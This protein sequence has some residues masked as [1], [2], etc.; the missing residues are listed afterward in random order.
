MTPSLPTVRLTRLDDPV[1]RAGRPPG[2]VRPGPERR[3]RARAAMLD[4]A[5]QI[6]VDEG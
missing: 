3:I 5:N 6:Q 2:P 4:P 1:R